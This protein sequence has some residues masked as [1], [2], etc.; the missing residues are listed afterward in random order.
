MR[1]PAA[2]IVRIGCLVLFLAGL[3]VQPAS[4]YTLVDWIRT[5]PA[6][7][8]A[9]APAAA[10]PMVV[11]PSYPAPGCGTPVPSCGTPA[12]ACDARAPY[13]SAPAMVTP[14]PNCGAA[15]PA[16]P[17]GAGV[18]YV[19]P[20]VPVAPVAVAAPQVRYRTTWVRVPTTSYRPVV[21]YDPA[22]GWPATGMQPCTTY[23]W[24]LRR[25]PGEGSGGWFSNT[26]GNLFGPAYPPA[27]QA[28]GTYAPAPLASP[29]WLGSAAPAVPVTPVY[30]APP[31][32]APGTTY[33][34]PAPFSSPT[35]SPGW[36][37]SS[38]APLQPTAPAFSAPPA[39]T[40]SPATPTPA[41]QP[42]RLSPN[43]AQGLQNLQPI[44][45]TRSYPPANGDA[46][47]LAPPPLLSPTKPP[48]APQNAPA[49]VSPV[50]DPD[51]GTGR[52][53]V[54]AAPS[55]YDPNGRTARVLPLSTR[56]PAAPIRWSEPS[57]V[58][59]NPTVTAAGL[60]KP[61]GTP[62]VLDA[63]GWQAVRN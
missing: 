18:S 1:K 9:A 58:S 55:L 53:Q 12:P 49:N 19:Q 50:P 46:S 35:P 47:L 37:P 30:P 11:V 23:T 60:S 21:T 3:A 63:G 28:V 38:S 62:A 24:Q 44:P 7:A 32:V 45:E 15:L 34:S 26:F 10:V 41:D 33:G 54:P 14:A 56:W 22:T 17:T 4:G 39:G 42:P 31:S 25:V 16:A 40:G 6:S 48:A 43:E 5:W 51:A 61:A 8:P 36:V 20:V 2:N 52:T 29:G 27:G 13:Y 57:A 59:E